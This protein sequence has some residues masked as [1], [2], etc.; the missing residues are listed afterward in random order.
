MRMKR[1]RDGKDEDE[2]ER[3]VDREWVKVHWSDH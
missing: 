1:K 2:R 3:R